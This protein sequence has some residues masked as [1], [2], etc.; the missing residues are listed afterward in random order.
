MIPEA[1]VFLDVDDLEDLRLLEQNLRESQVILIF[2]S[3]DY[4]ASKNCQREY[5]AALAR[6]RKP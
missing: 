4:V 6:Y 5:V 1:A 2:L 3:R